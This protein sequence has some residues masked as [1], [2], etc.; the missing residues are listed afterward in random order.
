MPYKTLFKDFLSKKNHQ[1]AVESHTRPVW[2]VS[3]P[4][5]LLS[6]NI[7]VSELLAQEWAD[8]HFT[9][10]RVRVPRTLTAEQAFLDSELRAT[11]RIRFSEDN[12]PFIR[13]DHR[14]CTCLASLLPLY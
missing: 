14:C 3:Y 10:E 12:L 13:R 9:P 11:G 1:V 2:K 8:P 7:L 4:I 5:G 6:R